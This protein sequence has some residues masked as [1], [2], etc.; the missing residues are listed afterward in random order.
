MT[1]R[2]N[3]T[4]CLWFEDNAEEAVQYYLATF[5]NSAITQV[6]RYTEQGPGKPGSVMAISFEL[7]GRP[8]MALNG[9]AGFASFTG[10]ISFVVHCDMQEELDHILDRL[11]DG[12]KAMQCGWLTDRFGITW[13][14]VPRRMGEMMTGDPAAAARVVKAFMPMV[15]LDIAALEKAYQGS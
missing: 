15:K 8:F 5:P 7:D 10:A 2:H 1:A 4:P 12:G 13:Q 6:S 11:L 14:V 9:G 3:L